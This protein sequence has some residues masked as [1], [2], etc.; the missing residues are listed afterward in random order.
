MTPFASSGSF[1]SR[2]HDAGT[3]SEWGVLGYT[4]SVPPGATLALDVRTGDTTVPGST[5]TAFTPIAAGQDVPG[6]GRYVQYRARFTTG[7]GNIT[8]ALNSVH[9]PYTPKPTAPDTTPPVISGISAQA[10]GQSTA[11]V[12]WATDEQATTRVDSARRRARSTPSPRT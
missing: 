10:T 9:L 11:R 12:T 6:S 5:W 4:A 8:P 1:L 7:N 2:V 3:T